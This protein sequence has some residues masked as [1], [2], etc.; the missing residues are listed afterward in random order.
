MYTRILAITGVAAMIVIVLAPRGSVAARANM[1][2]A[3]TRISFGPSHGLHMKAFYG[4]YDSHRDEYVNTDDSSKS[5]ATAFKIAYSPVLVKAIPKATSPMYFVVGRH[6]VGQIAFFGSEPG[7]S[8]YSP[9]WQEYL[10]RWKTGVT[11]VVLKSDN[12]ALSLS[13]KGKLTIRS[14][15]VVINSPITKVRVK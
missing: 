9:L 6:A 14:T 8:A 13:A 3:T 11:P 7:G 1:H 2:A 4:Y 15:M 12:Q 5:Q 10:V